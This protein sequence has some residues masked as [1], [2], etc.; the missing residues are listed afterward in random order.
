MCNNV[1]GSGDIGEVQGDIV[2]TVWE[3]SGALV[4][5]V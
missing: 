2:Q 1:E 4:E 5:E 3:I